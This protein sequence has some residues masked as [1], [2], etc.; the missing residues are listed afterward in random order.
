MRSRFQILASFLLFLLHI[1]WVNGYRPIV[2]PGEKL[3]TSEEPKPWYRTIY[4]DKVE[5][6]TPTVVAGVTFSRKP[7]ETPDPLEPWVSLNKNGIP[8]TIK[9]EIKNG[10]TKNGHPDY[11]TFFKEVHTKTLGYDDLK[12]ENMDYGDVHEEEVFEDEDETYTSL[13][14]IVRCT[15]KRYFNKGHSK[16]IPSEPFC[17]PHEDSIWN[18]GKTYFLT[19]YTHFFR[20]EHSNEVVE[21]V[22]IHMAYIRE[23]SN[24][25][26]VLKRDAPSATFFHSEWIKNADGVYPIEILHEWLQGVRTR[27]IVISVQPETVSDAEFDPLTHGVFVYLDE[28]SRVYK[29]TNKELALNDAGITDDKWYYVVVS[30][31]TAVI[32][33]LVL[34]YFFIIANR[35]YSD[36]SEVTNKAWQKKHR[37]L[38]KVTDFKKY[39]NMKNRPYSELP[40]HNKGNPGKQS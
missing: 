26:G 10:R 29:Q 30:I 9:P 25:K 24:E 8:K 16:N 38:G 5:I 32:V 3:T 31:P 39:K 33:A 34:M 1:N 23:K 19:W 27:K 40:M 11:S 20:D 7:L 37:V 2:Q 4:G 21:R 6:V 22:R 12:A 36:F 28:G 14:P 13:N 15:P 18:V 35:R 17:T